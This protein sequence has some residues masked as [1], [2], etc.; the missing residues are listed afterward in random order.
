MTSEE[1]L[2]LQIATAV[3]ADAFAARRRREER[4]YRDMQGWGPLLTKGQY[5]MM[6]RRVDC[7]MRTTPESVASAAAASA[8]NLHVIANAR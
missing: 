2:K 6:N 7:I 1:T 8:W 3:A 4:E 5:A